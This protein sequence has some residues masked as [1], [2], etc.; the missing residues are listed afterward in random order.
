MCEI[1]EIV[2]DP[3]SSPLISETDHIR[4]RLFDLRNKELK[5]FNTGQR[6]DID[7]R[8]NID[9]QTRDMLSELGYVD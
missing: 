6:S 7:D 2:D 1:S 8:P 9:N 4:E 5:Q 3:E